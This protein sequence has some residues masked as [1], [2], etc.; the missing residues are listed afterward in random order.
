MT[1][2]QWTTETWYE[3]AALVR[4]NP[5]IIDL[6]LYG[7]Q[8]IYIPS[9]KLNLKRKNNKVSLTLCNWLMDFEHG[10]GWME[11]LYEVPNLHNLRMSTCTGISVA[12]LQ[13]LSAAHPHLKSL[14]FGRTA[15]PCTLQELREIFPQCHELSIDEDMWTRT[16][17]T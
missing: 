7:N 4:A 10:Q 15:M 13:R 1:N 17:I 14:I 2:F 6:E 8:T 12:L 9:A 3:T 16:V 5:Q 11:I